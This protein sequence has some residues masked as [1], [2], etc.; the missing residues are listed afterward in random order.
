M[1]V[2]GSV[3]ATMA[4][5][6]LPELLP[7]PPEWSAHEAVWTAWP[8]H[9]D[10]WEDDL[11]GARRELVA[12]LRVVADVDAGTGKARGE[13]VCVLV[14]N[15]QARTSAEEALEGT[16]A[17]VIDAP[18]GDIWLRD[19][20]PIFTFSEDRSL[21]GQCF[22]F[23]GWGGKYILVG[24]EGV[25]ARV[26]ELAGAKCVRHDWVLE[27]GALD[28]DGS[29][30]VLTTRE[31]LLNANRN[32]GMSQRDVERSLAA[33]LGFSKVVWL[34]EGLANDHTD[35]HVDNLARFVGPGRVVTMSPSGKD[36]PN[37]K[38]YA[39]A[40][41][42]LERAGLEVTTIPSPGRVKNA[43]GDVVPASYMNFYV[44]NTAVTVP[45]YGTPHDDAAVEALGA[46]FPGRHVVGSPA[47]HLL[48]GGGAFH[49]ITQQQPSEP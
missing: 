34:D 48:T 31:C 4:F 2:A 24:D 27:G 25:S 16:G 12:F 14:A 20:G 30:T 32:G 47:S 38:A 13:R 19:T 41:A 5:S 42:A 33:D 1:V 15:A 35:G 45:T 36:D 44:S 26:C 29:G 22:R 17:R 6:S 11:E 40:R 3:A 21:L 7:P 43:A 49:C 23:N 18:F 28:G 39:A 8:S 10:L 37:A 46:L 9:P